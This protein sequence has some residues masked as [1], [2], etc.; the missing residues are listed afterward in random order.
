[1]ENYL[2]E[3]ER[4]KKWLNQFEEVDQPYAQLLI[5][6]LQWVSSHEFQVKIKNEIYSLAE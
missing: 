5:Q 4:Y 2:E 6:K 3:N 1:M